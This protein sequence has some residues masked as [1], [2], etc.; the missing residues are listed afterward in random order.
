VTLAALVAFAVPVSA[1][2]QVHPKAGAY[3]G[4]ETGP[5]AGNAIT[6]TV[7]TNRTTLRKLTASAV[8]KAGCKGPYA[9]Y[10]APSGP[11]VITKRGVFSKSS[12]AYPGPKLR[13]TVTGHFTSPT[14]AVGRIIVRFAR[15]KGCNAV[16]PFTIKR[17]G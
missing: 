11:E 12:R 2:T 7:A 13:I 4:T 1:A 15:L 8:V 10:Q 17:N 5:G 3:S 16:S 6:F 9:A 14:T